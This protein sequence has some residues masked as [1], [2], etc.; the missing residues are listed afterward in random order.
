MGKHALSE[1]EPPRS[2]LISQVLILNTLCCLV[3]AALAWNATWVI[4]YWGAITGLF[5]DILRLFQ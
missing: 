4:R 3:A 2:R 1:L 5:C